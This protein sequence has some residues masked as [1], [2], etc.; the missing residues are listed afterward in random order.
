MTTVLIFI[1]FIL[2]GIYC[3]L[4]KTREEEAAIREGRVSAEHIEIKRIKRKLSLLSIIVDIDS[5]GKPN[6]PYF[7]FGA[8]G[9]LFA[10]LLIFV[11]ATLPFV[12]GS[13]AKFNTYPGTIYLGII[14]GTVALLPLYGQIHGFCKRQSHYLKNKLWF[15]ESLDAARRDGCD[16]NVVR[17]VL[18]YELQRRN[19]AVPELVRREFL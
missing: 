4:A 3:A 17:P 6:L 15:F 13:G 5:D 7:L 11:M 16:L 10:V 19:E 12:L 1:L 9:V 14:V 2:A 8:V 18:E